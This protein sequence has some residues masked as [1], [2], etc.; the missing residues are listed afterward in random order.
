[1]LL[2]KEKWDDAR[3]GPSKGMGYGENVQHSL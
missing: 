3:V 1:M 2:A